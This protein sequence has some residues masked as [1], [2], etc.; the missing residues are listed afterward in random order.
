MQKK[1]LQGKA[2]FAPIFLHPSGLI[3]FPFGFFIPLAVKSILNFFYYVSTAH[4]SVSHPSSS[5]LLWCFSFRLF[6]SC[7]SF[8][9]PA[10]GSQAFFLLVAFCWLPC[11]S[12]GLWLFP[13][14]LCFRS[15][16]CFV[17][18]LLGHWRFFENDETD[19]RNQIESIP[20]Q[21]PQLDNPKKSN[22]SNQSNYLLT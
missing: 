3:P 4:F 16:F 7:Q 18:A 12:F 8:C 9:L 15:A 11:L 17:F 14:G 21:S 10:Q 19:N 20:T 22:K 1:Q 13:L 2:K 6:S 5:L